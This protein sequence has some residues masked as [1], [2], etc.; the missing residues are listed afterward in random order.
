M[1]FKIHFLF[2]AF[3]SFFSGYGQT[4][5]GDSLRDHEFYVGSLKNAQEDLYRETL[6]NYRRYISRHPQDVRVR[7]D[8]CKYIEKAFYD[9]EEG[10][11]PKYMEFESCLQQLCEDFPDDPEVLLYKSYN[12]YGDSSIAFLERLESKIENDPERWENYSWEVYRNLAS[13]YRYQEQHQKTIEAADKA[14]RLNDTL[15]LSITLA[16]AYKALS[17]KEQAL[18]SLREKL[19][20]RCQSWESGQKAELLLELGDANLAL[21]MFLRAQEDTSYYP[22][23]IGISTSL[24]KSGNY[25]EARAYLLTNAEKSWNKEEAYEKLFFH[26]LNFNSDSALTSYN[27]LRDLGFHTDPMGRHRLALLFNDPWEG[28]KIR[29]LGGFAILLL[30]I[31]FLIIIPYII[32]L[33]IHYAGMHLNLN[34]IDRGEIFRWRLKSFWFICSAYLLSAFI[35]TMIFSY[36]EI[37]S[38]FGND[39]V[40]GEVSEE[41]LAKSDLIYVVLFATATT[42]LWRRSDWSVFWGSEWSKGKIVGQAFLA[43]FYLKLIV[44][45]CMFLLTQVLPE[46]WRTFFGTTA[47]IPIQ[48]LSYVNQVIIAIKNYFGPLAAFVMVVLMAP[49]YE[50]IVFRGVILSSCEKHLNFISANIIQSLLFTLVHYDLSAFVFYFS[51]GM[52]AGY[53]RNRSLGLAS[54]I[55]FHA[56]N[57]LLAFLA[58][59]R[60]Q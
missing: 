40:S 30:A 55:I 6:A 4:H 57:N 51:F 18:E 25:P 7:I 15:D 46:D 5:E 31:S 45:A 32:I 35:S 44:A 53:L 36:W 39:N 9:E 2:L 41:V 3:L 49:V 8:E 23:Y 42:L 27:H 33:P 43:N 56:I 60:L 48:D 17:R 14:C 24:E 47:N 1:T 37:L 22:N 21:K 16:S 54:G 50:E 20:C 28:W 26:D 12:L 29:D 58:L 34:K 11:N 52:I 19:H 10:Y 38:V 59:M 13:Q